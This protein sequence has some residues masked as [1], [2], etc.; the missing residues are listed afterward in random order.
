MPCDLSILT[1][2]NSFQTGQAL[3]GKNSQLAYKKVHKLFLSFC[4]V[5]VTKETCKIWQQS[6]IYI[7]IH[8]H[9]QQYTSSSSSALGFGAPPLA[10]LHF[11]LFFLS[12]YFY[13]S[14]GSGVVPSPSQRSQQTLGSFSA[15]LQWWQA[16]PVHWSKH[17]RSHSKLCQTTKKV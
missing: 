1:F 17:H 11:L 2:N 4:C 8:Q 16:D 7:S 6:F 14:S 13:R 9:C 5:I 3:A 10:V 15:L 12:C